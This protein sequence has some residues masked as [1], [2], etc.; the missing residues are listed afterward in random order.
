MYCILK[1]FGKTRHGFAGELQEGVASSRSELFFLRYP[2]RR[3][4]NSAKLQYLPE[5]NHSDILT[6]EEINVVGKLNMNTLLNSTTY[7]Q[8]TLLFH[9]RSVAMQCNLPLCI[10]AF[11]Q[12]QK[13]RRTLLQYTNCDR[14]DI[15]F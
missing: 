7:L 11:L 14:S 12:Q 5:S 1:L 9:G 3:L 8:G 2:Y 10:A 4:R 13:K 6:E 15:P